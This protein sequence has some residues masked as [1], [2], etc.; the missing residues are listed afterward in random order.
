LIISKESKQHLRALL[1]RPKVYITAI[2][3][4][5]IFGSAVPISQNYVAHAATGA[6]TSMAVQALWPTPKAN[7]GGRTEFI[8]QIPDRAGSSY[9]M[10]WYVDSG[11]WNWMGASPNDQD[12][13]EANVNVSGW[14]WKPA[15]QTY[16]VHFVAVLHATGERLFENIPVTIN[17]ALSGTDGVPASTAVVTTDSKNKQPADQ[18]AFKAASPTVNTMLVL[19]INKIQQPLYVNPNNSASQAAASTADPTQKRVLTRLAEQPSA[20]WFGGWNSNITADVNGLVTTA[21][22]A[23]QVPTLVAYNIPQ[24][25]CGGYSSGGASSTAG[26]QQ[27]IQ[28][29]AAGIGNRSAIV[30]LEPDALAGMDCLSTSD[31]D[32]RASM[33]SNAVAT[34]KA[35]QNTRVYLDAGHPGWKT[36]SDIAARLR[37]ANIAQADGFSLNVSNFIS[38]SENSSYGTQIASQ[39]GNKHFVIDTSRN[40]NGASTDW[41]NPSGRAFGQTP[42]A[43]TGRPLIDDYLWVKA[44]GESDGN[45]NNGPSA[46]TWWQ[47]Y[48]LSL[49][50]NSNW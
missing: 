10:F 13:K 43:N 49:G 2:I 33:L 18:T 9:D 17:H 6:T 27:W 11:S 41:C 20:N 7:L 36:A 38:T 44:P 15:D 19:P 23:G 29:M 35:N 45:C 26:Y 48:A 14:N 37:S 46:G 31:Q 8:S 12:V 34:L 47:S 32:A 40:G 21:S 25:D 24:R 30:I 42:S 4:L 3:L 16:T 1:P 39:V 22:N 5:G 50:Y 28:G